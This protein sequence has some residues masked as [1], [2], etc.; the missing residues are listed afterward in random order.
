MSEDG[1]SDAPRPVGDAQGS[2]HQPFRPARS[3]HDRPVISR[4][5]GRISCY[6]D[7]IRPGEDLFM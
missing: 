3:D 6:L 4:G 5:T 7:A 1:R 2:G